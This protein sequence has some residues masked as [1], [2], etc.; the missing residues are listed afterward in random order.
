MRTMI[1]AQ[2]LAITL[3]ASGSF[4]LAHGAEA[5]LPLAQ[6]TQAL[7]PPGRGAA[8]PTEAHASAASVD[9]LPL[10]TLDPRLSSELKSWLKENARPPEEYV[11]SKFKDH[12]IV[13]LGEM[14]R[15]RHDPLLVQALIPR[16]HENGIDNLGLEFICA[17]EQAAVDSLLAG[18]TYDE[19]LAN[20]IF[21]KQWPWWGYQEYVD[22]LRAAWRLDHNIPKGER[23]FR[24]VGLNGRTDFSYFWSAEDRRN[25][26]LI[27]KAFPDGTSDEAMAQTIRREIL[28]KGEKALIYTG[29][30][31]AFTR[32]HQ[33]MIDEKTGAITDSVTTRM[34]NRIHS[35]IGDRCFLIYLHYPW[36]GEAGYST[37][38]VYPADGVIDALFDGMPPESRRLGFDVKGSPFGSLRGDSSLW[39]HA[40]PH[41]RL[42][43]FCDG[44]IFQKPLSQYEG[45]TV[46]PGWFN[47]QNRL[48]AI[49]QIAN[50]DPRVKN[51]DRSVES[52]TEMLAEDTDMARRLSRFR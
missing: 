26:E 11:V 30:Y 24:I 51:R 25:P 32:F 45:V 4:A 23:R 14:H 48:E 27:K 16:L 19:K 6:G 50:V 42:D 47:E 46:V 43:M 9:R 12:D 39:A 44:W 21:W 1:A 41:F 15:V 5:P 35:D 29:I 17:R 28:A 7:L 2:V 34:G 33:P 40:Y 10:P 38:T 3:F 8:R 37:A 31:H 49:S 18:D 13:F 52:L 20:W 22:I 36:P